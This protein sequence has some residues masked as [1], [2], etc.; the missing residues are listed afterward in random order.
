MFGGQNSL[1]LASSASPLPSAE[2]YELTEIERN[3]PHWRWSYI[4]TDT[5][6]DYCAMK[7]ALLVRESRD[8]E[9]EY[10]PHPSGLV[11]WRYMGPNSRACSRDQYWRSFWEGGKRD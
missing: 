3:T 6:G 2:A 9:D 11:M 7:C 10:V 1:K 8:G 5:Q 4:R